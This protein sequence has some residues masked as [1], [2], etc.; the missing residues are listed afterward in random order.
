MR[1]QTHHISY[2]NPEWTV[3]LQNYQHRCI[4]IIQHTTPT[5][6]RYSILVNFMHAL[7]HEVNRYRAYL[8]TAGVD[9]N[10]VHGKEEDEG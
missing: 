8:D 7:C 2:R 9:L 3:E 10:K 4:S 6:E 1:L 5:Q